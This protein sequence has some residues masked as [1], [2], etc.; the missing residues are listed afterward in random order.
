MTGP[1]VG[2]EYRAKMGPT[3][4]VLFY[5]LWNEV[6]W[7]NTKWN[8]YRALFEKDD[9][10]L[11]LKRT[12]PTFFL[13]VKHALLEDIV[14]HIARL[15]DDPK[16]ARGQR[17]HLTLRRLP[18]SIDDFKLGRRVRKLIKNAE[19]STR[20][21]EEWRHRRIAHRELQLAL[22]EDV[23]PLPA[24]TRDQINAA[25]ASLASILDEVEAH[26]CEGARTMFDSVVTGPGTAPALL[27]HLG[28]AVRALE[29][30][31]DGRLRR[32]AGG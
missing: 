10:V 23:R 5:S 1:E 13:H 30:D 21:A 26:Y 24:M 2:R 27:F 9:T 12:A 3:L 31:L 19:G 20:F 28:V 11:L 7:V 17:D 32:G 16:A 15:M 22:K 14:L 18:G 25:L 8:E 29:E 6:A 4:G